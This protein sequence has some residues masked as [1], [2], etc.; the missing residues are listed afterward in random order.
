M[1][2]KFVFSIGYENFDSS[3]KYF[4]FSFNSMINKSTMFMNQKKHTYQNIIKI[5]YCWHIIDICVGGSIVW[6]KYNK[7]FFDIL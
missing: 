6:N 2:G 3:L 5:C 1:M 4:H 7:T